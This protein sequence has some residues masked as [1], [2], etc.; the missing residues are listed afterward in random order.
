[1]LGSSYAAAWVEVW[2]EERGFKCDVRVRAKVDGE[3]DVLCEDPL[4]VAEVTAVVDAVEGAERELE[5]L[6]EK[7]RE[8]SARFGR[9]LYAAVLAVEWAPSQVAQY[10]EEACRR[11]GVVLVLGR[12]PRQPRPRSFDA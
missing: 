9:P 1:M 2:L 4:V 8:A 6:L 3:V 5:K 7:A 11:R 12:S 10:L